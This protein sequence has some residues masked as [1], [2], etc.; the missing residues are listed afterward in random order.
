MII[1]SLQTSSQYDWP[2]RNI[3]ISNDNGYFT[4]KVDFFFPL[5]LPRRLLDLTVYM[6]NMAGVL[7]EAET[8]YPSRVPEVIAGFF[9]GVRFAHLFNFLC[10]PIMRIYVLS[11]VL[12]CPLR[13]P[14]K[15]M[16]GSFL[17]PVFCVCVWGEGGGGSPCL[18]CVVCDCL[19]VECPTH[20][21]MCFWFF[22][23]GCLVYTMLPVSL[24]WPFLIAP[25]VSSALYLFMLIYHILRLY[26]PYLSLLGSRSIF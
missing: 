9:G 17:P 26:Y 20:I 8:A 18:A 12:W 6:S 21:M 2:L 25:S 11:F 22:L 1:I 4:F 19:R 3:H 24:D 5:S 10:C 14:P 7:Y 23:F 13:S 16:F 15:T